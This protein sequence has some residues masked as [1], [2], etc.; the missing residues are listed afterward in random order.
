MVD[1]LILQS[2]FYIVLILAI[3]IVAT[4]L[5]INLYHLVDV[6]RRVKQMSIRI[7]RL[8]ILAD[9][10]AGRIATFIE[11]TERWVSGILDVL[12]FFKSGRV[13]KVKKQK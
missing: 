4:L 13:K 6:V 1:I 8:T 2:I 3:V 12:A 10:E 7:D 5:A 9:R 11:N